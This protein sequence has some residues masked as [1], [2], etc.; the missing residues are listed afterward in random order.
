MMDRCVDCWFFLGGLVDILIDMKIDSKI[1]W[2][3]VDK[4]KDRA[5]NDN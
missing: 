5:S 1:D 2:M 4:S 3:F